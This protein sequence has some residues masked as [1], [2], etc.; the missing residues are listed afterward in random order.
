[1]VMRDGQQTMTEVG[2]GNLDWTAIIKATIKAG[3]EAL[4]VEQ[5]I[6]PGDPFESAQISYNNIASWGFK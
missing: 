3:V 4:I 1:M 6:C 5:D 2:E